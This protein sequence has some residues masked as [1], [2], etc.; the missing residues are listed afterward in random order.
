MTVAGHGWEMN[1]QGLWCP[2]C[3]EHLADDDLEPPEIC[4]NCGW[5][6]E[7]DPEKV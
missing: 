6:D 5:P 7:F 4:P 3:G 2:I 1:E